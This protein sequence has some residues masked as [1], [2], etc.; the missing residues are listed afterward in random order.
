MSW[1]Q[2]PPKYS[3]LRQFLCRKV[4]KVTILALLSLLI[5]YQYVLP[6]AI[7]PH[8]ALLFPFEKSN[9]DGGR[10]PVV[11]PLVGKVHALFG[12]PNPTYERALRLQE[13]HAEQIG[14]P[15]FVLREKLLSGLWSKPAYILC[16][17]L[18]ELTLPEDVRL[19]WLMWN[20]ADIVIMNSQISLDTFIPPQIEFD[21]VNLLVT[22]DR[23]G[24]NNGVFLIRVNDW[25]VKL[26]SEVIAFHKVRPNVHLK[27]S[28]QS[29]LENVIQDAAWRKAVVE[30]PQYW[31]NAYPTSTD[32]EKFKPHEFRAGGLQIHFA[33]NKD[34]GRSDRMN[35]W[36]NISEQLLPEWD[37]PVEQSF[38]P[39]ALK[40]F[41]AELSEKRAS[42][43]IEGGGSFKAQ[44][45]NEMVTTSAEQSSPATDIPPQNTELASA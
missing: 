29:A 27:Y 7:L 21:Y 20:D 4:S 35:Q 28:E 13:R 30:V 34:G 22:N 37:M 15:M 26:L 25:S 39:Q 19:Q 31:F 41:W 16:V 11:A 18:Q 23:H 5:I 2:P 42:K 12:D 43:G 1:E 33:G 17:I 44:L 38:Y 24:L 36:M 45:S 32:K 8:H 14:H 6:A 3:L 40:N 10:V 9:F